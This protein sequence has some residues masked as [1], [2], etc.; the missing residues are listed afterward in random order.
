MATKADVKAILK[1]SKLTGRQAAR[2]IIQH[3]VDN[4][5]KRGKLLTE[6]QI[7]HIKRAVANRPPDEVDEYNALIETYRIAEYTLQEAR[8]L[9]LQ[10]GVR[11]KDLTRWL[12]RYVLAWLLRMEQHR[13]P[14]IVTAKQLEDLKAKARA[15]KLQEL[16]CLN[17]VL[18]RRA[19]ETIEPGSWRAYDD[20]SDQDFDKLFDQVSQEIEGL[21]EEGKLQPVALQFRADDDRLRRVHPTPLPGG[22]TVHWWP[23]GEHCWSSNTPEEELDRQLRT[24]VSGEQLYQAGLPEW[25]REVDTYRHEVEAEAQGLPEA[26]RGPCVAVIQEP[27]GWPVELDERGYYKSRDLVELSGV[28]TIEES[29]EEAGVDPKRWLQEQHAAIRKDIRSFLAY[30][31][32]MEILSDLIGVKLHE[33]LEVYLKAIEEVA[34]QYVATISL[35]ILKPVKAESRAFW[36]PKW[37]ARKPELPAFAIEGLRPDPKRVEYLKQRMGLHLGKEWWDHC[38]RWMKEERKR[39]EQEEDQELEEVTQNGEGD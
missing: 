19:S 27:V 37:L 31:V 16:Y 32:V 30:L 5:H 1:S 21:I 36:E 12:D 22:E 18:C 35:P 17:E 11:L 34:N 4:D 29:A 23:E 20:L 14:T 9:S 2:L 3:L 24:Y 26:E 38:V 8:I 10:I 39:I 6:P 13:R 25:V 33:D 28:Q 15:R 7:E